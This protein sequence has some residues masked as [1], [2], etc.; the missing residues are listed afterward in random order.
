MR[1][2]LEKNRSYVGKTLKILIGKITDDTMAG[3]T[4][5]NHIVHIDLKDQ[6]HTINPGDYVDVAISFAGQ[7]SLKGDLL[8]SE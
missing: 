1:L 3:R 5:T 2:S 6:K 4:V 8:N 7:H